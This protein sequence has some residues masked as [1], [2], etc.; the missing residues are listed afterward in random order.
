M[1]KLITISRKQ[2]ETIN[3]LKETILA[4]QER[5]SLVANVI[6]QGT[7]DDVERAGVIG[8]RH[9]PATDTSTATYELIL[10][11]PDISP[12]AETAEVASA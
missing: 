2:Y 5:L 10:E 8:A 1:E 11:I 3:A 6:M 12:P 9:T 4:A 7:N